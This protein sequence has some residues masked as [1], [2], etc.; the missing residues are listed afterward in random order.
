[1]NRCHA[2]LPVALSWLL[3]SAAGC[4]TEPSPASDISNTD[5]PPPA[6]APALEYDVVETM[7]DG[8]VR[9]EYQVTRMVHETRVREVIDANGK[10]TEEPTVVAVPIVETRTAIVPAGMDVATFLADQPKELTEEGDFR[11]AGEENLEYSPLP[12]IPVEAPAP[13]PESNDAP[14]PP[15]A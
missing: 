13:P 1:M 10:S 8:S 14:A 15:P 5:D 9:V 2:L 12:P 11:P 7:P 3:I 4:A 6:M